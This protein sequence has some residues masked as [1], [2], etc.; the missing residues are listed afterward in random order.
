MGR[1]PSRPG[2]LPCERRFRRGGW[3]LGR[4]EDD[5][6]GNSFIGPEGGL[7]GKVRDAQAQ[8][9]R[10]DCG[11]RVGLIKQRTSVTNQRQLTT[12]HCLRPP[13]SER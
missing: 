10:P 5:G 9:W 1:L 6:V 2:P 11:K 3:W 8:A 12:A 7:T 4:G 13:G